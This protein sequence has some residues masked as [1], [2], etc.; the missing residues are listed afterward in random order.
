M[1]GSPGSRFP[2]WRE[3]I[4]EPLFAGRL[5]CCGELT[6]HARRYAD[7]FPTPELRELQAAVGLPD[8][9]LPGR[10]LAGAVFL[11]SAALFVKPTGWGR[12]R[13]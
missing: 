1:R 12:G 2:S 3:G 9:G 7:V 4:C 13:Q 11:A 5:C 6:P 8:A 10:L